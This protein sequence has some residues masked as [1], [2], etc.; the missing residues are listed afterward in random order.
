MAINVRGLAVS[1]APAHLIVAEDAGE[2]V[3][4]VSLD[5][6]PRSAVSVRY[7]TEEHTAK[8]PGDYTALE[9]TLTFAAGQ[10]ERT[11]SVPI[12]DDAIR[13][14]PV[15]GAHERFYVFLRRGEGYVFEP[16]ALTSL[17]EIVDN[18][19]EATPDVT[20]PVLTRAEVNSATLVLT[21]DEPLDGASVPA[22]GDFAVRADGSSVG[23]SRVGVAGSAV[24][25]TLAPAVQANQAVLL[26]YTPA[27][28]P[29]QDAAGNDA[30]PLSGQ[31]VT[32]NTG[33]T[34]PPV[35]RPP[36]VS[37]SCDP[38]EVEPG[39]IVRLRAR[40][41]DP[42][43]D[44]LT[45]AWSAPQ[46]SFSGATD[47]ARA[48]WTAPDAEGRVTIQVRVSDGRGGS[49]SAA[50]AVVVTQDPSMNRPPTV[51]VSCDP[52]EVQPGGEVQLT[53]TANDPDGD[54]V[55]Y[56]W[57]ADS[58]RFDGPTDEETARWRAPGR[59][60][61]VQIRVTASDGSAP[62]SGTVTVN[63]SATAVPALPVAASWLLG[64]LLAFCGAAIRRRRWTRA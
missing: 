55:T 18:D 29:I 4:T 57:S 16:G 31:P 60:G 22:T 20:P 44:D 39:G 1:I 5:P 30:A 37:V 24:T 38:C 32:N 53:A 27:A 41:S 3:L 15:N 46:G 6:A 58:G 8:A 63:V 28:D 19:G 56:R 45:Y 50:V 11:V 35:N 36:G 59:E 10:S 13:E 42:D 40:A 9:D 7:R 48:N 12:V 43:G 49:A 61:P 2:A 64:G 47:G 51:S 14:D 17:V 21:Y 23:V 25:L 34:E 33:G 54:R 26:D 62:A 52:C